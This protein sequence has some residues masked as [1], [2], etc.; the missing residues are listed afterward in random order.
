MAWR[1]GWAS[2]D[3]APIVEDLHRAAGGL[4]QQRGVD[5]AH[6]VLFAAKAAADEGADDA[7]LVLGQAQG[8]RDLVP[9]GVGDLRTDVDGQLLVVVVKAGG[10]ADAALGLHEQVVVGRGA[11]LAL[12]DDVRLGKALFHV[13]RAG[14]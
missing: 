10:H 8:G 1:L 5:L 9:V 7:H 2:S 11:V 4:G 3:S 6:D 13:A 12:D 14:P